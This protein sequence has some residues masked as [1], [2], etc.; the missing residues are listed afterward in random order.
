MSFDKYCSRCGKNICDGC[1]FHE[2]LKICPVCTA[3]ICDKCLKGKIDKFCTFCNGVTE[4]EKESED[5][6][7]CTKC[8]SRRMLK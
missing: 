4:H 3:N 8:G 6:L 1:N 2:E 7:K 5:T